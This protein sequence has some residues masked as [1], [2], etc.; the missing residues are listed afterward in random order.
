M[1]N[2]FILIALLLLLPTV[3]AAGLAFKDMAVEVDGDIDDNIDVAG[4]SFEAAPGESIEFTI[5]V[6][7]DYSAITID[8]KIKHIDVS[9]D[10]DSFCSQDLDDSIEED[11]RI[12]DLSPDT[13]DEA[14]FRFQ[15][16]DCAN[17]GNYDVE[18]RV[19]G[20]DEDGTEYAIEETITIG[21]DKDASSLIMDFTLDS[22][23]SCSEREFNVIVEAHNIGATDDDAGLLVINEDL[24]INKFE[25]MELRTGKWTDEDTQFLKT[26]TFTVD[27]SVE[28]GEYDLRAEVEYA[29]NTQEIKRWITIIVPECEDT[30]AEEQPADAET[31]QELTA[32][33]SDSSTETQSEETA[34][35]IPSQTEEKELFS[36]PVLVGVLVAGMIVL[37][38]LVIL[39]KKR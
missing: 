25:F 14:V 22:A 9:I 10:V 11:I 4:G 1:K 13:N 12:S 27:D 16:P 35:V 33:E 32:D 31:D 2:I 38:I 30:V 26:Y 18:I 19:D 39:L 15:I 17:E 21:V 36:I 24:D 20:K 28:S 3:H 37:G 8:H 5:E 29:S 7:N 6:E 34:T 23:M